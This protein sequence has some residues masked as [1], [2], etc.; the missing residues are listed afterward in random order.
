M[1]CSRLAPDA[2]D[3]ALGRQPAAVHALAE[4]HMSLTREGHDNVRQ[5][6]S[7]EAA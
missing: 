2:D 7:I 6:S 4:Q 1:R 3:R 5:D